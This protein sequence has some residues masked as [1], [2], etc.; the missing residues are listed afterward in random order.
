[1]A[2]RRFEV[3]LV[4]LVFF[5]AAASVPPGA[6]EAHYLTKARHSWDPSFAAGDFFLGTRDA[7]TVF[8][9][10]AGGLTTIV[11][12]GAAAWIGRVI[13]WALLA[14]AWVRLCRAVT[15]RGGAVLAAML[16]LVCLQ[17]F[18]L[19]GEWVAGGFEAKPLA[20]ALVLLSLE[21]LIRRRWNRAWIQLGAAMAIHVLVGGWSAMLAA[22]VWF[23]DGRRPGVVRMV[24]AM[25]VAVGLALVGL[26]P[27]V[28]LDAGTPAAVVDRASQI[29]VY[30]RLP[31]HLAPAALPIGEQA[32]RYARHASMLGAFAAL[33]FVTPAGAR[34]RRLRAWIWS[35]TTI[36]AVGLA[37]SLAA[38]VDPAAAARLL[39]VYWF[40]LNDVA[41]ALGVAILTIRGLARMEARDRRRARM[42]RTAVTLTAVAFLAVGLAERYR[43][44]R[45]P[46]DRD[47]A[48][49]DDWVEVCR[50]IAGHT[51][52]GSRFLTPRES[53]TFTW[54]TGRAQVVTEKDIPQDAAGIV[55]WRARMDDVH[56]REAGGERVPYASLAEMGE[57]RLLVLGERY[58][59]QYVVTV[60]RPALDL[61]VV[62][63]N[64]RHTVYA[65]SRSP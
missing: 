53:Q 48:A 18:D 45:P 7:H 63:S 56:D 8:Y 12:L 65:L 58:D 29:Y 60:A 31:H 5:A 21:S 42:V 40:R 9:W 16:W 59:A 24:P 6:N 27:V 43:D 17:A 46:A 14:W 37:I 64:G 51:P 57:A 35:A 44:A 3:V 30:D 38:Q 32:V 23:R 62:H 34:Q 61:P 26:V 19:S 4:F 2:L 11:P 54:R 47:V 52:A 20:Y 33:C 49:Y 36:A 25:T 50:W 22:I 41:L 1:M 28:L 10:L 55:Q 13:S 39:R 15:P